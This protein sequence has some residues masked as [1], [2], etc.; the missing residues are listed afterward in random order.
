M[1][2]DRSRA[3]PARGGPRDQGTGVAAGALVAGLPQALLC[4]QERATALS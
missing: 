4:P 3:P 1:S 2:G